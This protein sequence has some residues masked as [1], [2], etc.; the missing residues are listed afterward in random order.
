MKR[1]H[2]LAI[3][4]TTSIFARESFDEY[5]FKGEPVTTPEPWLTGPLLTPSGHVVPL[6]HQNYEPYVYWTQV[7]DLYNPHWKPLSVPT[8]NDV[9]YQFTMQFGV[10]PDTEFDIAPQ[11]QYN[12]TQGQ[13]MW[14]VSDLPITIAYQL[15]YDEDD[16]WSPGIKL[17]FAA[18]VPLG[19]YDHLKLDRLGVDDGGIGSWYP[20]VGL[21]F[22]RLHH[23]T[24]KQFLSWRVFFNYS[25]AT[26]VNVKGRSI[27]GGIPSIDGIKRTRGTV[28]PGNIFLILTGLEYSLTQNWGLALDIQYQHTDKRRFSGHSFPGTKPVFPSKDFFAL[29]PALEYNWSAN[30]GIIAG[31]WFT[32]AGRNALDFISYVIAL[33]FYN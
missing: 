19:K 8:F 28:Y 3:L 1:T 9:L 14:R 29:A 4:L 18:N 16:N 10:L 26:P 31:P 25:I 12:A 20:S 2:I 17:R 13:H 30:F 21:V 23:I 5:L 33:N 7:K 22:T 15:L 6:G 32:V 11:F 24:G 27:Y